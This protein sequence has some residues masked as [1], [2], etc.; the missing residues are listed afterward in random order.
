VHGLSFYL[1]FLYANVSVSD[2]WFEPCVPQKIS[3]RYKERLSM[4]KLFSVVPACLALICAPV[5]ASAA[6]Q[7]E[8]GTFGEWIAYEFEENGGKVCYMI[9]KPDAVEPKGAKRGEIGAFITHRPAEGTKNV[10]TYMTGYAYK[11]DK[12]VVVSIDGKKFNLFTQNDMA[13]ATDAGAD[14]ALADAIKK[15]NKM[16]VEGE[17]ARG[18]KTKDTYNLKGSTKAYEAITSKCGV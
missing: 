17:S 15:G 4:K 14:L 8:I 7:T 2:L 11:K 6:E 5:M 9:S 12:D 1:K 3:M 13:W 16:V 10:F 18:T